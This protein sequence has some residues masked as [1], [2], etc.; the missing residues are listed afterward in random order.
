MKNAPKVWL[1]VILY[2]V[3]FCTSAFAEITYPGDVETAIE[4]GLALRAGNEGQAVVF[5]EIEDATN[6][7]NR[8]AIDTY[9]SF[10]NA[11]K[12]IPKQ[13]IEQYEDLIDVVWNIARLNAMDKNVYAQISQAVQMPILLK[14]QRTIKDNIFKMCVS[15]GVI[16]DPYSNFIQSILPPPTINNKR[17]ISTDSDFNPSQSKRFKKRGSL[18]SEE[19]EGFNKICYYNVTGTTYAYNTSSVKI[20]PLSMEF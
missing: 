7:V 9:S 13:V 18:I 6:R 5:G 12:E 8:N 15:A 1:L 20:C 4:Q 11:Q 17:I 2:G 16:C 14:N 3:L 19:K 10:F